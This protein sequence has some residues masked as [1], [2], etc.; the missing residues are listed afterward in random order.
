MNTSSKAME[1]LFCFS[2]VNLMLG[3]FFFF[4]RY[5]IS[6]AVMFVQETSNVNMSNRLN[7]HTSLLIAKK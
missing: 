4:D 1:W 3:C 2:V 6:D 5:D 7:G